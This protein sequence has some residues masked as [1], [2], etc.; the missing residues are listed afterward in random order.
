MGL[1]HSKFDPFFRK[2][3]LTSILD[4]HIT[5][6]CMCLNLSSSFYDDK[7]YNRIISSKNID[8]LI[9]YSNGIIV[10]FSNSINLLF[11]KSAIESSELNEIHLIDQDVISIEQLQKNKDFYCGARYVDFCLSL[12]DFFP[13]TEG[14]LFTN[15]IESFYLWKQGAA[16]SMQNIDMHY[17]NALNVRGFGLKLLDKQLNLTLG[18]TINA[19]RYILDFDSSKM[20][21]VEPSDDFYL[22]GSLTKSLFG[23]EVFIPNIEID[24]S[25]LININDSSIRHIF[26]SGLFISVAG[27]SYFETENMKQI[28]FLLKNE[29]KTHIAFL[30]KLKK[31]FED[32]NYGI[33]ELKLAI[34]ADYTLKIVE[35]FD[36][37]S[38]IDANMLFIR[39][40]LSFYAYD[41]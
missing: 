34:G 37:T 14:N 20:S 4:C 13:E 36:I 11:Q 27:R 31:D 32:R 30:L 1:K 2:N 38:T 39:R 40:L 9:E 8:V 5:D 23:R 33:P 22:P 10:R 7:R 19:K 29:K 17:H 15:K 12:S 41:E 35:P 18:D 6:V 3:L 25:V 21:L 24:P 26:Y 16:F 28:S